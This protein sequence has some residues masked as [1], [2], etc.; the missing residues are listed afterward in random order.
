MVRESQPGSGGDSGIFPQVRP[1]TGGEP[2][3]KR[4]VLARE[5]QREDEQALPRRRRVPGRERPPA[6]LDERERARARL[7]D[8]VPCAAREEVWAETADLGVDG[9]VSG[10]KREREEAGGRGGTYAVLERLDDEAHDGSAG[11]QD[12]EPVVYVVEGPLEPCADDEDDGEREVPSQLVEGPVR[13]RRDALVPFVG[14]VERG[15]TEVA[16]RVAL[17]RVLALDPVGGEAEEDDDGPVGQDGG[18]EPS[19]LRVSAQAV[20]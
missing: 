10:G 18:R 20:S 14:E 16:C 8:V 5:V 12:E 15:V 4:T 6:V 7:R 9:R 1:G 19:Q 2:R 17:V 3:L 13:V 11:R